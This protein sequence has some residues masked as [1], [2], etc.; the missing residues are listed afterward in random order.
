[1]WSEQGSY[2]VGQDRDGVLSHR[3]VERCVEAGVFDG[4]E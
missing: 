2:D 3:G 4:P 1:V